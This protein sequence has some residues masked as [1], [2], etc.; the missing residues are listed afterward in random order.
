MTEVLQITLG[1]IGVALIANSIM[2]YRRRPKTIPFSL[3]IAPQTKQTTLI[4]LAAKCYD[5]NGWTI[6]EDDRGNAILSYPSSWN[7]PAAQNPPV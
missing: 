6:Y 1:I 3:L 4:L 2:D 7:Q 5:K